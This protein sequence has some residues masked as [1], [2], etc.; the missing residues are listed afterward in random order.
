MSKASAPSQ[1]MLRA[2]ELIRHALADVFMRGDTGD[3]E[4][5]KIG[6]SVVEVQMSPDLQI[7]TVFVRPLI[8]GQEQ[9][10]LY[11]CTRNQRYMRGLIAPRL[12]MKFMPQLKFRLDTALDYAG[13]IDE[14]LHRPDVARDLKKDD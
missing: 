5:E 3:P 7:A 12:D 6:V 1:R 9:K 8:H 11:A 4:L 14:L 10:L 2:G 13:K